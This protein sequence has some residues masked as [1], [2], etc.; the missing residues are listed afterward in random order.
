MQGV[1]IGCISFNICVKKNGHVIWN[2]GSQSA[3]QA[4]FI[5]KNGMKINK[6]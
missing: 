2:L 1:G 4:M 5:E 3:K 6:I